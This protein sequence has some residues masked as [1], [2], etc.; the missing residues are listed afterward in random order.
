MSTKGDINKIKLKY[1][2]TWSYA[3]IKRRKKKNTKTITTK[4]KKKPY[5]KLYKTNDIEERYCCL[6]VV[7]S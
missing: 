5:Q 6:I 4:R 7:K 1:W 3:N 2:N